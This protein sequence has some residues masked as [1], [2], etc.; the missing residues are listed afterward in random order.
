MTNS[1]NKGANGER[2]VAQELWRELG[3]TF[4]RDLQQYQ[5]GERGDLVCDDPAW[6]FLIEVKRRAN[7]WTCVPAWEA[8]AFRAAADTKLH[9]AIIYRFDRQQWRVRVYLD[10]VIEAVGGVATS[11]H[12]L[13]TDIQG[14]AWVAR[15]IMARRAK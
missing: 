8:Q 4:K 12:W 2:E 14:F 9:P 1:R 6:P 15:E 5:V 11:G 7:G 13:E 3:M 10:A